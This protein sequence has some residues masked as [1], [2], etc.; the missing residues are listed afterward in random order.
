MVVIMRPRAPL[1]AQEPPPS[2]PTRRLSPPPRAPKSLR[3]AP[4]PRRPDKSAA[5]RPA[6]SR[7][8]HR[9]CAPEA[10]LPAMGAPPPGL[11]VR[12]SLYEGAH[13]E[14]NHDDSMCEPLHPT[15]AQ[16]Q[17]HMSEA[18]RTRG[19]T[20]DARLPA[21]GRRNWSATKGPAVKHAYTHTQKLCT[22]NAHTFTRTCINM[23]MDTQDTCLQ[24]T[25]R[26]RPS[27][28]R[29][30]CAFLFVPRPRAP[31]PRVVGLCYS[32][33]KSASTTRAVV[34]YALSQ[35]AIGQKCRPGIGV[36]TIPP[37]PETS[38]TQMPPWQRVSL[39]K[40]HTHTQTPD[41]SHTRAKFKPLTHT[42]HTSTH[43]QDLPAPKLRASHPSADGK[44]G[45][46]T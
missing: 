34:L 8:L 41:N 22:H 43:T 39:S 45:A 3:P 12:A 38:P 30:D 6:A 32:G 13:T 35:M 11:A 44:S 24:R 33:S 7:R 42:S 5:I 23:R 27:E 2:V 17:R 31:G 9:W 36:C 14:D 46:T 18:R 19:G 20:N 1:T 21:S 26:T 16:H 29:K 37:L 25:L 15:P 28:A 40:L 4:P 10:V